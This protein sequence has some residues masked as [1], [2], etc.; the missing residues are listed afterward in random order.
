MH[1]KVSAKISKVRRNYGYALIP[2]L[3][4]YYRRPSDGTPMHDCL[5]SHET[6]RDYKRTDETV[7]RKFWLALSLELMRLKATKR[8][9]ATDIRQIVAAFEKEFPKVG[10]LPKP[11]AKPD[12]TT[13]EEL[14]AK[15]PFLAG[16]RDSA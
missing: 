7:L 5:W 10:I 9:S 3:V 13:R 6:I 8:I 16:V 4:N 2:L 15:Y 14:I 11:E 1:K 12:R